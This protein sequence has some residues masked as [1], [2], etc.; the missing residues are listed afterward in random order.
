MIASSTKATAPDVPF[1]PTP[2]S[3]SQLQPLEG[4]QHDEEGVNPHSKF[5]A[6]GVYRPPHMR[7]PSEST[8]SVIGS[9]HVAHDTV[10][11]HSAHGSSLDREGE[12]TSR[13]PTP[14]TGFAP[15]FASFGYGE[16]KKKIHEELL[17]VRKAVEEMETIEKEFLE[18]EARFERHIQV[19]RSRGLTDEEIRAIVDWDPAIFLSRP[20]TV[21]PL[22]VNVGICLNS[23][24]S[25]GGTYSRCDRTLQLIWYGLTL[26]PNRKPRVLRG[27]E[28]H[29]GPKR[30]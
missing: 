17:S 18:E 20:P 26:A 30:S 28:R 9:D 14:R 21:E 25:G 3:A 12:G 13:P 8:A 2:L 6:H 4:L 19:L 7:T 15:G 27:K 29:N 1:A 22:D 5:Q 11:V 10:T 16:V 24:V 23:F